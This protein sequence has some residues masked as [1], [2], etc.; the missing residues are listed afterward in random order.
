GRGRAMPPSAGAYEHVD[1]VV[2]AP[3]AGT[4]MLDAGTSPS[5]AST[6]ARDGG[7]TMRDGGAATGESAGCGCRAGTSSTST[8]GGV[9]ALS[10]AALVLARRMRRGHRR[11]MY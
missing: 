3:D 7:A 2:S 10:L 11:P 4:P 1:D 6:P 9:L 8:R 5:D